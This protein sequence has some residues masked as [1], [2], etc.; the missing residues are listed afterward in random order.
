[1][2]N[3]DFSVTTDNADEVK[4]ASEEAIL[5]ALE[6]IGLQAESYAKLLCPVD[7]GLLRNSITHAVSGE[8]P[9]ITKYTA[10]NAKNGITKSG[11][12]SG[13]ASSDGLAVYIGTNVE[14]A[15]YMEMGT[16]HS[17]PHPFIEPAVT[18]HAAEYKQIAE[19][20]LKS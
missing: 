17:S 5:K 13:A 7:T 19:Q 6:A 11:E 1:M 15:A 9:S 12:Y 3:I 8:S 18:N 4:K 16:S 10:D 20:M 14:Y 2:V